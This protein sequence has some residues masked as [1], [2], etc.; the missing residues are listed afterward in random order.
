M[1]DEP[2]DVRRAS[3][4]V[5]FFA[6]ADVI[7]RDGTCIPA[8][9]DEL[10]VCGCYITTIEAVPLHTKLRLRIEY[11]GGTSEVDGKVVYMQSGGGLGLFGAGVSF[12]NV[13]VKQQAAINA[14]L[15][16]LPK[17][18]STSGRLVKPISER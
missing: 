15:T 13:S 14:W 2:D 17:R 16:E 10:S 4:R 3:P 8:Q 6:D 12:E 7:L 18:R 9:L 11:D 5:P 1:T